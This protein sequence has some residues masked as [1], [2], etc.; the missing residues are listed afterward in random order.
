M[1]AL[2]N[3]AL[4]KAPLKDT[5]LKDTSR[6]DHLRLRLRLSSPGAKRQPDPKVSQSK[7][8]EGGNLIRLRLGHCCLKWQLKI[9]GCQDSRNCDECGVEV[10]V[11]QLP[12]EC[13]AQAHVGPQ[14]KLIRTC[15]NNNCRLRPAHYTQSIQL[16]KHHLQVAGSFQKTF[17]KRPQ[18]NL[19]IFI[20]AML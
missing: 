2:F 3:G 5:L 20:T 6:M 11:R 10:T 15:A 4:L 13:P 1:P 17:G 8:E 9:W 16:F 12:L 14:D 18:K 19:N 7:P